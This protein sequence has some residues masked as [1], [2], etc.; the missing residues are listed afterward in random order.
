MKNKPKVNA[1]LLSNKIIDKVVEAQSQQSKAKQRLVANFG[2]I[3]PPPPPTTTTT[4][5]LLSYFSAPFSSL[6]FPFSTQ[7]YNQSCNQGKLE[8]L[9]EHLLNSL[10]AA[11][12]SQGQRSEAEG[13]EEDSSGTI[14]STIHPSSSSHFKLLT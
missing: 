2:C 10:P 11:Q 12:F 7:F 5:T 9:H 1:P 6:P 8:D 14:E 13:T 4:L 3:P